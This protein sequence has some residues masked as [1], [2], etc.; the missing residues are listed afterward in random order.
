MTLEAVDASK[1]VVGSSK[2]KT[3]GEVINS[4]PIPV[5]LF[6]PPDIPRTT[7]FPTWKL[8]KDK[9]VQLPDSIT[10][11]LHDSGF[12]CIRESQLQG[13]LFKDIQ[14]HV[15]AN[16]TTKYWRDGALEISKMWRWYEHAKSI[17]QNVHI[18][19]Y[20]TIPE[21]I[22]KLKQEEFKDFQVLLYRT[23]KALNFCFIEWN[24]PI[25]DFFPY[26]LH[27]HHLSIYTWTCG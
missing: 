8:N 15:S 19:E 23:F 3:W 11:S 27:W 24:S 4:I 18:F 13:G 6:S 9:R 22:H 17:Q 1:P 25:P 5:R 20:Q 2:N 21:N 16:S 7:S 14:G 12:V 26:T 10:S